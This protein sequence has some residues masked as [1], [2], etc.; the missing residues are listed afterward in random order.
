MKDKDKETNPVFQQAVAQLTD[1]VRLAAM[2]D[3]RSLLTTLVGQLRTL[4]TGELR[5]AYLAMT[6]ADELGL[7]G[8]RG[9]AYHEVMQRSFVVAGTTESS[10]SYKEG[11]IDSDDRLVVSRAQQLGLL[12]GYYRLTGEW[13][14]LRSSPL[15]FTHSPS[16]GI[17]WPQHQDACGQSWNEFWK[18]R[19]RTEAVL[20]MGLAD[21]V[22]R[23]KAISREFDKWGSA[24]YMN[25]D[26][27]MSARRCIIDKIKSVEET[28][29]DYFA[30]EFEE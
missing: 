29:P 26:C 23:L 28:L 24:S 11:D 17:N 10:R 12:T 3:H 9:S 18:D 19:T 16:C 30:E 27:R 6:L 5:F 21:V 7:R 13:E 8:L 2:C 14:R 1:L 22:G 4:M 15:S 20:A 25:H